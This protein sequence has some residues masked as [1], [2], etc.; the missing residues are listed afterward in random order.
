MRFLSVEDSVVLVEAGDRGVRQDVPVAAITRLDVL[1][2]KSVGGGILRGAFIGALAG[3][4]V[5]ALTGLVKMSGSTDQYRGLMPIYYGGVGAW[6]GLIPGI[7]V[8]WA[9]PS[10]RWVRQ[11]LQAAELAR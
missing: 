7:A 9:V 2:G 1:S 6:I 4:T 3:A 5:G 8:G 10:D 11:N